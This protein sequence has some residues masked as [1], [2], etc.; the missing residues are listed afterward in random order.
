MQSTFEGFSLLKGHYIKFH[1]VLALHFETMLWLT[2]Q[3][4][5]ENAASY[6]MV[7]WSC[8]SRFVRKQ[9]R[10]ANKEVYPSLHFPEMYILDQGYKAF[11][12]SHKELCEPDD[13]KP[14]L[15]QDHLEDMKRF[16]LKSKSWAGEKR[17]SFRHGLKL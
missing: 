10:A 11:F 8:R 16:R 6:G 5:D 12:E 3:S 15:H 9:D 13:Y 1:L 14:M 2:L 4:L 7:L 17:T